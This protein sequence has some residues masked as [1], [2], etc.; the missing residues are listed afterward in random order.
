MKFL[1]LIT[2]LT[3]VINA[4]AKDFG[5]VGEVRQ[6]A[7]ENLLVYL[8]KQVKNNISKYDQNSLIKQMTDQLEN[9]FL[10][11]PIGNNAQF[12]NEYDF[13]PSVVI[14]NQQT[15]SLVN[16]LEHISLSKPLLI[17]D[18]A[19][20]LQINYI[21]KNFS[22]DGYK[23]IITGG[24]P[25]KL[26]Q[27]LKQHV[28]LDYGHRFVQRFKLKTVPVIITQ[29]GKKLKIKEIAIKEVVHEDF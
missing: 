8:H 2:T 7:E 29:D 24:N 9:D 15:S 19:D 28:Y 1:F 22:L 16:P 27:Q 17:F 5:K 3:I 4:Q 25:I 13:D 20:R 26:A 23:L 6:I 21:I 10:K 12:D 18:G 11:S 14:D